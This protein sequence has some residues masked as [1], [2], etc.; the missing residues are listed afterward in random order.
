M[1]VHQPI[2]LQGF[3]NPG[4]P[5]GMIRIGDLDIGFLIYHQEPFVNQPVRAPTMGIGRYYM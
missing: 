3:G 1:Q 5:C 2:V 4:D